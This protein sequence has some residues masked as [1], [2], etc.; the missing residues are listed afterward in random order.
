MAVLA[1]R[2]LFLLR[3]LIKVQPVIRFTHCQLSS[4]VTVIGR[5]PL[6]RAY[7]LTNLLHMIDNYHL[8]LASATSVTFLSIALTASNFDSYLTAPV[9]CLTA[10]LIL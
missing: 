2:E 4:S 8:S 9:K 1:R 3:Q 6:T 7:L 10:R 5:T